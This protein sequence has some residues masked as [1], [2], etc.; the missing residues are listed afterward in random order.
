MNLASPIRQC[1]LL[2]L[3]SVAAIA[4]LSLPAVLLAGWSGL[5]GLVVSAVV[6]LVPGLVTVWLVSSVTV[7]SIRLWLV[8]G[9]M[10]VR[11]FVVLMAALIVHQIQP[12]MGLLEFYIWLVV[13]YNILLLTETWLLLPKTGIE[14]QQN[15][16]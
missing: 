13:F 9:G 8:L 12:R 11:M 14:P 15:Q 5:L 10:L 1:G 2:L 16:P 4:V 7:P 6:C 3:V